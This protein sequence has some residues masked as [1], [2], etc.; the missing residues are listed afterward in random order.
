MNIYTQKD[1]DKLADVILLDNNDENI[2]SIIHGLFIGLMLKNVDIMLIMECTRYGCLHDLINI[3][4]KYH[5]S[6]YYNMYI[7]SN[8][9]IDTLSNKNNKNKINFDIIKNKNNILDDNSC[10]NCL[11][12][13][14][15]TQNN[16]VNYDCQYCLTMCCKKCAIYPNNSLFFKL[17]KIDDMIC[18][19]C[20]NIIKKINT[21]NNFDKIKF[22]VKGDIDINTVLNLLYE[23]NNKCANCKDELLMMNYKPYCC[24]QFSID[25]LDNNIPHDKDNVRITCYY[26]NCEHHGKFDQL[27]KKCNAGCHN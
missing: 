4:Y 20:K 19:K 17:N 27:N 24:Y 22:N 11:S 10:P 6:K 3:K 21:H 16:A 5:K 23:Q 1:Y 2:D 9:N 8:I 7:E 13:G 12:E 26:C 15:Y 18:I 25:R 14:Y